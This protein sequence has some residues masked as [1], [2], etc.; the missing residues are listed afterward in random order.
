MREIATV[1]VPGGVYMA[2]VWINYDGTTAALGAMLNRT[3]LE[4]APPVDRAIAPDVYDF[5]LTACGP[6]CLAAAYAV[7]EGRGRISVTFF[8]DDVGLTILGTEPEQDAA[9][10][11]AAMGAELDLAYS[12]GKIAILYTQGTRADLYVCDKPNL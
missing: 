10:T 4:L 5:D 2:S 8:S 3:D 9:C 12:S 11:L 7:E 1:P 6:G